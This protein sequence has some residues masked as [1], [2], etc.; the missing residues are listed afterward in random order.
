M[1]VGSNP[2]GRTEHKQ[3]HQCA[4]VWHLP[5]PERPILLSPGL[6]KMEVLTVVRCSA[7]R[8][9]R[10]AGSWNFASDGEQNIPDDMSA[11]GGELRGHGRSQPVIANKTLSDG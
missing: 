2:T 7:R 10:E 11:R 4:A 8:R 1:V 9:N 3:Q 6:S 5:G